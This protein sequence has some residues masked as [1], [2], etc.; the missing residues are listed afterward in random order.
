VLK[1]A[2]LLIAEGLSCFMRMIAEIITLKTQKTANPDMETVN[3]N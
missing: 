3:E 1:Y 2:P